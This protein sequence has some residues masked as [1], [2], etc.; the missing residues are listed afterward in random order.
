M[1]PLVLRTYLLNLLA[2]RTARAI[3]S[4]GV[5]FEILLL[6]MLVPAHGPIGAAW[7][8]VT[9]ETVLF[10]CS[11]FV[12][13][14]RTGVA[15]LPQLQLGGLACAMILVLLLTLRGDAD[16]L[17]LAGILVGVAAGALFWPRRA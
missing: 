3:W 10:G 13:A 9:T 15:P 7:A 4:L 5:A 12:I 2:E 14:R 11:A 1:L 8:A 6:A 17:F 16:F